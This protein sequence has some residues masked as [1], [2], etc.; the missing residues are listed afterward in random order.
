MQSA[1]AW[2]LLCFADALRAD[3]SLDVAC[4][5]DEAPYLRVAFKGNRPHL[6]VEAIGPHDLERLVRALHAVRSADGRRRAP[7]GRD[8][9]ATLPRI[10]TAREQIHRSVL[11]GAERQ[12]K[13]RPP[14]K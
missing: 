3:D 8:L 9:D 6:L 14:A 1:D 4:E 5:L 12:R 10:E 13:R 7:S 2:L 11:D